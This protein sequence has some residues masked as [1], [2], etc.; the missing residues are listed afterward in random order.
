[1]WGGACAIGTVLVEGVLKDPWDR[2]RPVR[3]ILYAPTWETYSDAG[4]FT[5]L[6]VV[7]PQLVAL[8]PELTR[9]GIRVILRPHPAT[10][11]RRPDLRATGDVLYAA[12]A[13]PGVDKADA[14]QRADILISD[15]SGVMAE[16]LFTEKPSVIPV[17]SRLARKHP[18]SSWLDH[19]DPWVYR[20]PM[21]GVDAP[22]PGRPGDTLGGT[23]LGQ[24]LDTIG[25]TDPLRARR[26]KAAS[27]MF[28]GHR[29]LEDSVR[30]FDVALDTAARL[31]WRLSGSRCASRSS[32]ACCASG[33]WRLAAAGDDAE[34]EAG[35]DVKL[36]RS[37][38]PSATCV[39][40]RGR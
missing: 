37:F 1:M 6:D 24:L 30:T 23:A 27:Q 36:A 16:F 21:T 15:V 22:D 32:S 13:E 9:Q 34:G 14:F 33:S 19:E 12:G 35:R 17:T 18:D 10:G 26:A 2:P 40:N 28:R 8:L 7:G 20:W 4:D 39:T 3:T 5:S 38:V 25:A 11:L 31:R 29:S